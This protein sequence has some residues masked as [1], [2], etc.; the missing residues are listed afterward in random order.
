[1]VSIAKTARK[2][3]RKW[4]KVFVNLLYSGLDYVSTWPYMNLP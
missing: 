3:Y 1:M 4:V 2:T